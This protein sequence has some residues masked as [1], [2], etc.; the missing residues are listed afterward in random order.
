MTSPDGLGAQKTEGPIPRI[1]RDE[2]LQEAILKFQIP[3]RFLAS[4]SSGPL[5]EPPL[6]PQNSHNRSRATPKPHSRNFVWPTRFLESPLYISLYLLCHPAHQAYRT[7]MLL[8]MRNVVVPSAAAAG[9][10][11]WILWIASCSLPS[12]LT[13]RN[14]FRLRGRGGKGM[15]R[16][17][18][19]C[20]KS[21]LGLR[22]FS[23]CSS[24]PRRPN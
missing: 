15:L 22:S 24:S 23:H 9:D 14:V 10:A 19:V 16:W 13:V 20:I 4:C 8:P 21:S 11:A 5:F 3:L 1:A 6:A 12:G 18:R 2:K 7:D 17:S